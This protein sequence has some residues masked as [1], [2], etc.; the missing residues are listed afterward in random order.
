MR[1]PSPTSI[2]SPLPSDL[3]RQQFIFQ[4]PVLHLHGQQCLIQPVCAGAGAGG[5]C[6]HS[7]GSSGAALGPQSVRG[8]RAGPGVGTYPPARSCAAPRFPSPAPWPPA[9]GGGAAPGWPGRVPRSAGRRPAEPCRSP[10]QPRPGLCPE[11][12]PAELTWP[13]PP[14]APRAAG[15]CPG[16][17]WGGDGQTGGEGANGPLG[18][19]STRAPP[20]ARALCCD[21]SGRGSPV[22]RCLDRSAPVPRALARFWLPLC[23]LGAQRCP[24]R[25]CR[26]SLA[27]P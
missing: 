25:Q 9:G 19:E 10:G 17:P 20:R 24:C 5:L 18:G 16:P 11:P 8:D 7:R 2:R 27:Q 12:P 1:D 4:T 15:A 23:G 13:R 3:Q 26:Q 14:A 21:P 6:G 22:L